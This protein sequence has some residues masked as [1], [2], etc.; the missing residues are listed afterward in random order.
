M[1]ILILL[2]FFHH[3]EA[4]ANPLCTR[5]PDVSTYTLLKKNKIPNSNGYRS[6]ST[7]S[8]KKC[9][10]ICHHD[11]KCSSFVVISAPSTMTE[12]T[13]YDDVHIESDF[14]E[15]ANS[16]YYSTNFCFPC[17]P[18]AT[19]CMCDCRMDD[20]SKTD[21]LDWFKG[22]YHI[23]GAYTIYVDGALKRDALCD[24]KTD[25]GGYTVFLNRFN[26]ELDFDQPWQQYKEGFGDVSGEFWLGLESMNKITTPTGQLFIEGVR[27]SG[28]KGVTRYKSFQ[29]LSES[30]DYRLDH[31]ILD[32][33]FTL[34]G[35]EELHG[36][37]FS[38]KNNDND[39]DDDRNCANFWDCGWWFKSCADT[40]FNGEYSEVG[41]VSNRMGIIW[42]S[43]T[44]PDESLK[45]I[46]MLYRKSDPRGPPPAGYTP[47]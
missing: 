16:A 12:C 28:E 46:R 40:V 17:I 43:F 45:S 10:G 20:P 29:I 31:G 24:M 36:Q 27:Y 47:P 30:M 25:G 22:G 2:L 23:N 26:G 4:S 7:D 38:T 11:E 32:P 15:N 21:C 19:S 5:K 44:G 6:L 35:F 39:S 8:S 34:N 14:V 1:K 13:F 9:I 41:T 18:H 33:L 3:V 42:D 37:R